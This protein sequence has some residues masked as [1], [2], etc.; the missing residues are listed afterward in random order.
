MFLNGIGLVQSVYRLARWRPD[1][2]FCK[3]GFVCVPVGLAAYMMRIPIVLHDSDAHPGLANRILARFAQTIATGTPQD[4]YVYPTHKTHYIGVPVDHAFT[5]KYSPAERERLKV[6]QGVASGR[7]LVVVTGG[8]LGAQQLNDA[9]IATLSHITTTASVVLISGVQHYADIAHQTRAL[10]PSV[11]QVHAFVGKGMAEI[12]AAADV[13]VTRAGATTILELA[14]L[15]KPTILVPNPYLT[16]GHQ[17]KN[18]AVYASA[19]AVEVIDEGVLSRTP[20]KLAERIVTLVQDTE[21][22]Q[23]L[24]RNFQRF[25]MPNAADDMAALV[26]G[27]IRCQSSK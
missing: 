27:A 2:V 22:Q 14:A 13:V 1:V 8:G 23:V 19:D 17:L 16:G 21:R 5:R 20:Q 11:F 9:I 15:A 10:K 7:P 26:V 24:A 12:L 6:A 25:A 4:D 3:G 18:A